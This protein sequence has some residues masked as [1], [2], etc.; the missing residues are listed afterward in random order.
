[1]TKLQIGLCVMA[2]TILAMAWSLNRQI[3]GV[4]QAVDGAKAKVEIKLRDEY[5]KGFLD[6]ACQQEV[7]R[8]KHPNTNATPII[9]LER[10]LDECQKAYDMTHGKSSTVLNGT[11]DGNQRLPLTNKMETIIVTK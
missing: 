2:V 1:M 3:H 7:Y 5:V 10:V 11:L 9:Q 6:G 8:F 4:A